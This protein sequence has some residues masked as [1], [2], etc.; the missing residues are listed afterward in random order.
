M[1]MG[2][3]DYL[4]YG[5][6]IRS[7]LPLPARSRV[8]DEFDVDVRWGARECDADRPR[9]IRQ[10]ARLSLGRGRGYTLVETN[11]GYCLRFWR[12][13]G[14]QIDRALRTVRVFPASRLGRDLAPLLLTSSVPTFL[15]SLADKYVVHA[16]AV[17]VRGTAVGFVGASGMGKSTLAALF[18]A[19]GAR[20][21]T[22]DLLHIEPTGAGYRCFA[23]PTEIRLR[24]HSTPLTD[25]FAHR[26]IGQTIDGRVSLS[27]EPSCSAVP[28]GALLVPRPT[29]ACQTLEVGRVSPAEG[30]FWL[31]RCSRVSG[32]SDPERMRRQFTR[33]AEVATTVPMYTAV[34]PWGPPFEPRLTARLLEAL[35]LQSGPRL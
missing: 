27:V 17:E 14:F 23:G 11:A 12:T 28:L 20:P 7:E 21:I 25:L 18:C 19:S 10:L 5:L 33:M 3:R 6:R 8:A 15:L 34:I 2:P 26:S 1:S 30:L 16:S 24:R 13:C 9:A 32:W 35:D 31:T 4:L 29:R 22:D